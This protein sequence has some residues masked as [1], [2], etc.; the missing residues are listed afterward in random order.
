MS[1][2]TE[3]NTVIDGRL[4]RAAHM[5]GAGDVRVEDVPDSV[6]KQPTDALVR[7]T[8]SCKC[9]SDLWPYGSMSPADRPARM[10]RSSSAS[11]RTPAPR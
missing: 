6:I 11:W 4:V 8:A 10:G 2:D 9:G 5:Y 7:V 1:T 3:T